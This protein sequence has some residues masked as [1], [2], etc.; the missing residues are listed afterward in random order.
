MGQSKQLLKIGD[1]S[2]L[3]RAIRVARKSGDH[4]TIVVLGA[5]E[6]KHRQE[7]GPL[8]VEV[9]SNPIWKNGI[10][11]SLKAGLKHTSMKFPKTES[12]II[13]VCDQPLVTADHLKKIITKHEETH[14]PIIASQ[15]AGIA[16]VPAL[17]SNAIFQEIASLADDQGAKKIIQEHLSETALV[18]FPQGAIDLDTPEEY[19]TFIKKSK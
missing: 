12:V 19:R 11:G 16:G 13:M 18:D 17:F 9:V 2:L 15:Y 10:G 3:V 8:E 14:K 7:I 4:P 5:E 1:D 6:K